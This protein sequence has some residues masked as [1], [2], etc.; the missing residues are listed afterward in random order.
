MEWQAVSL[1]LQLS[2]GWQNDILGL[3]S[4]VFKKE[5]QT[6]DDPWECL[7]DTQVEQAGEAS[8]VTQS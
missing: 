8:M 2:E 5:L 1:S 4:M 3:L 6:E 7:Q